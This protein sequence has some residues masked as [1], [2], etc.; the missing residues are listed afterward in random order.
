MQ[1]GLKFI[2]Y[3]VVYLISSIIQILRKNQL[4]L[5]Y[6]YYFCF[7]YADWPINSCL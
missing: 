7:F 4:D 5:L 3:N 6:M 2:S 1:F